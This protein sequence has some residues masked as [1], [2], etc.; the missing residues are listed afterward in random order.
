MWFVCAMLYTR[1][2]DEVDFVI[3]QIW[4]P[5]PLLSSQIHQQSNQLQFVVISLSDKFTFFPVGLLRQHCTNHRVAKSG[6]GVKGAS[7]VFKQKDSVCNWSAGTVKL[8]LKKRY[9]NLFFAYIHAWSESVTIQL[10]THSRW[11]SQLCLKHLECCHFVV[12]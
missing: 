4:S 3:R 2:L 8:F 9:I 5:I 1:V 12:C 10:K 11:F 6:A 7:I